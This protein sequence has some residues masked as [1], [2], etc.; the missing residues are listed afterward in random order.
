LSDTVNPVGDPRPVTAEKERDFRPPE[1]P[2]E[3]G[4]F[5]EL[6]RKLV[7]VPKE[8]LDKKRKDET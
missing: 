7:D 3:F 5:E 4:Q 1:A 2:P 6:A 8:E